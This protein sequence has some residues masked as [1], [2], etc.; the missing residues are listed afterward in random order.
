MRRQDAR[1]RG[2]AVLVVLVGLAARSEALKFN[3][4][5]WTLP[6]G[7]S[8]EPYFPG[9]IASA[10]SLALSGNSA[11]NG[12]VITYVSAM[13][14]A[15]KPMSVSSAGARISCRASCRRRPL[16]PW[17]FSL[18]HPSDLLLQPCRSRRRWI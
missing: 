6:M 8:I 1:P 12:P 3:A 7:F 16:C 4:S 2:L 13:S 15:G 5:Q 18:A 11:A 10:R 14:F 17:L 9:N